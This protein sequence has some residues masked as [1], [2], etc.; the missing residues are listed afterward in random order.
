MD[1]IRVALVGCGRIG[2]RH[3]Q[4]IIHCPEVELA[5]T[6]DPDLD[7]AAAAAVAFDAA[8][9]PDVTS[10]LAKMPDLDG[11]IVATP[12]GT[13]RALTEQVVKAGLNVVVERPMALSSADAK[14]MAAAASLARRVLAVNHFDRL[15]DTVSSA[16]R[17]FREG[18]LGRILEGGVS[19]RLSRSQSY[20]DSTRWRGTRAMDG[21]VLF[22]QTAHV[23]DVLLQFSGPIAEVFAYT[24]TLTH[25]IESEDTAV[26]V[27]KAAN[28]GL[29][30]VNATTSVYAQD[31]E[32]RLVLVGET[33]SIS[34]GPTLKRVE[35]WRVESDDEDSLKERVNQV[36]QR[37]SWQSHLEAL[38]DFCRAVTQGE[39]SQ[40]SG[41]SAVAVVEVVQALIESSHEGRAVKVGG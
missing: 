16:F 38:R 20:Y 1:H 28:G 27:L 31:L 19:V 35:A 25:N 7:R 6:V 37:P 30:T 26:G 39:T 11:V 17:V 13:H 40:L 2:Q 9:F 33:G 14:A 18:R 41:Q 24:G 3:L 21:G 36:A 8:S 15:L 23:L 5:A 12:S 10:L 29:F 32:E 22:N 4:A 34:L